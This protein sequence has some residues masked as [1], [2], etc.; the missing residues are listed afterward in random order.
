M[1]DMNAMCEHYVKS[2]H[3]EVRVCEVIITNNLVRGKGVEGDPMR[4]VLQVW[5]MDG[6]L[7]AENDPVK[8]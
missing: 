7:I 2:E 3:K 6:E 5:S 1:N 4:K 8:S